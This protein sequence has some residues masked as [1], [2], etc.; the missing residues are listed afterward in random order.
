MTK[1]TRRNIRKKTIRTKGKKRTTKRIT[2][3]I[4][5]K[6]RNRN[7]GRKQKG[8][9]TFELNQEIM[10]PDKIDLLNF[11]G[12]SKNPN[13]VDFL[14]ENKDKI[15]YI[16]LAQNTNPGEVVPLLQEYIDNNITSNFFWREL[17][18]NKIPEVVPLLVDKINTGYDNVDFWKSLASNPN[19]ELF[20]FIRQHSDINDNA[21]IQGLAQNT[22]PQVIAI[23]EEIV[24][25][26]DIEDAFWYSLAENE[27]PE[28][29]LPFITRNPP[30]SF[31][32]NVAGNSTINE[33][34]MN[35]LIQKIENHEVNTWEFWDNLSSNSNPRLFPYIRDKCNETNEY[36][37][38]L[39]TNRNPQVVDLLYEY[40]NQGSKLFLYGLALNPNPGLV[41][42]TDIGIVK[43]L[44]EKIEEGAV[45][46]YKQFWTA[47]ASNTNPAISPLLSQKINTKYREQRFLYNLSANPI[48]FVYEE[49][50]LK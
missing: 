27:N 1:K 14:I 31:W 38:A 46:N 11:S 6:L 28:I 30:E 47:L 9:G 36:L 8:G 16:S 5:T 44:Q 50:F 40:K 48:L 19:P 35:I 41:T 34:I 7:R 32:E 33:P 17:A 23:L 25:L 18:K 21:F 43:I 26:D 22:N 20:D 37:H 29:I 49:Y 13:A 4:K 45:D 42:D 10:S 15:I 12:L 2:K 24:A 3:R 39:A